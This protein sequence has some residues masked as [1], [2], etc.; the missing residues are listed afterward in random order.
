MIFVE[1]VDQLKKKKER[2]VMV[3]DVEKEEK[4]R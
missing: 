4:K 2:N 3:V 1:V